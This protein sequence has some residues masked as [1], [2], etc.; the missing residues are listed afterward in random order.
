M[1]SL[2]GSF[3]NSLANRGQV[4]DY[5]HASQIF[6]TNSFARSPKY[7]YLF[8]VN[9]V[10]ARDV[11]SYISTQ[12]IGY[13]VK[14]ID[15]PRFTFDVKDL[16]QYNRHVYIQDRVKYEP[17]NIVFHDDNSNGLR[18]LWQ[19]YYNYYYA[20]GQYSLSDYNHDDRYQTRRFSSWGLDNGS[21]TPFFSAVEI[22]SMFGGQTNKI[23]LMSPIITSFSHDKHDYFETQGIM[24]ATM[25]LRYNGVTYEDGYTQG[26]PGFNDA[27]YYDNNVS[28]LSGQYAGYFQ[29]PSTGQ[30]VP[31]PDNFINPVQARQSQSGS[32]G[33]IDQ[34]NQYNPTSNTGL[35]DFE[36]ASINYN[37][38][39]QNG[40]TVFPVADINNPVFSQ[41]PP[42]VQPIANPE[43]AI[44]YINPDTNNTVAATVNPYSD[45]TF[46][47]AL[48]NQGYNVTQ[49]NSA[50][51][52]IATV[53]QTTL[54][55]YGFT[56]SITA[57]TL[58]S[59]QYID[60]PAN[61]NNIGTINY[62]QPS[63][64][65]SNIDFT[66]PVSPVNPTYNSQT[67]QETLAS[68]GYRSSEIAIAASHIA[69]IN[70]A[71]GTNVANI[72][73]SYIKY[74]NNK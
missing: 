24:E 5:A 32:F 14:N 1:S 31:Q 33:F 43:A 39:I 40:N 54:D 71:P 47:S 44:G 36:L 27:A 42:D 70:I 58:L 9:F 37:N 35:T 18:E 29:D 2:L 62:G 69:Q 10:L 66:N 34:A 8:Y 6:R 26:I 20:D 46:Q 50:A 65:P 13:L 23:T 12:E 53:P 25:Q 59:Q 68:Q 48:F 61:V 17:V 63:S 74:N 41:N 56:N 49:I 67:W 15:L 72:A 11:P 30:L 60:N 45:G 22:Y 3:L 57:Q 21:L 73:E 7:K 28:D 38:S 16:N 64:I 52:F 4:H 19:N 55:Q 51:E